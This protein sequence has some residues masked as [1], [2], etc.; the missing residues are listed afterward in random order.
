MSGHHRP[1]PARI[2]VVGP[3]LAPLQ[4]PTVLGEGRATPTRTARHRGSVP[5][6]SDNPRRG[7]RRTPSASAAWDAAQRAFVATRRPCARPEDPEKGA[8]HVA[9]RTRVLLEDDIDGGEAVETIQFGLDGAVYEIDLSERNAA[10]LRDA[11]APFIGVGRRAGRPA[12]KPRPPA[13]PAPAP[14]AL[15][16][17]LRLRPTSTP[18]MFEP[19]PGPTGCRSTPGAG[20]APPSRSSTATPRASGQPRCTPRA[21]VCQRRPTTPA[22]RRA[23]ATPHGAGRRARPEARHRGTHARLRHHHAHRSVASRMPWTCWRRRDS[24]G[25]S[26][27]P[28]ACAPRS[29][30]YSTA[31]TRV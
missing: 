4:Q 13:R 8:K 29:G 9:Q 27:R 30:S 11:V 18:R 28:A 16:F 24:L 26:P 7:C 23:R 3:N 6:A 17:P 10:Q 22:H 25:P 15:A 20:P 2:H 5:P 12:S 1:D 21:P 19:G 14:V 31:V